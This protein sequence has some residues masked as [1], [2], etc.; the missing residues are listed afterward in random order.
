[1]QR[2]LNVGVIGCGNI[3]AAYLKA[4][5]KVGN[6]NIAACA[7]IDAPRARAKAA[8]F[9]VPRAC[10]V[11]ELL[12][13]DDIHIVL[14][15]TVPGAHADIARR[16]LAAGKHTYCEKP[17]AVNTADGQGVLELA[18]RNNLCVGCAPD[19]FL[20]GGIQTARKLLDAGLIGQVV[21]AT[22]N[23]MCHGHESWHPDPAFYYQSGGGPMFDMGP[24]YLTAMV[25]LLGPM[26]RVAGLARVSFPERLI[27]SEPKSGTR[28]AVETPTHIAGLLEFASGAIGTITTSFDVWH[29]SV[30]RIEIYGSEGSMRVPDPNTFSGPVEV[31]LRG[32]TQW[33]T[34]PLEF[35]ENARGIGLVDMAAAI[36]ENRPLRASGELAFHVLAA[37]EA[38]LE[39]PKSG[40][41]AELPTANRP[42]AL[43]AGLPEWQV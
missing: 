21:G 13:A 35:P 9:N 27:T 42:T 38:M 25:N 12:A 30:P 20:G 43:P 6:F 32:E 41:Y 11:E 5:P 8:E 4:A 31:R 14:N 3:S 39:T 19:T 28:I 7:D 37:M 22:A 40:A 23:M 26:R 34:M 24:Y 15:L 17:L 1:M 36:A 2:M 33:K 18:R 16:A 10:T 29:A